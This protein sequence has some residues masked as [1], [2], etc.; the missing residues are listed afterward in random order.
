MAWPDWE[1][2]DLITADGLNERRQISV[3]KTSLESRTSTIAM[4]ADSELV[5]P[6]RA[7]FTYAIDAVINYTAISDG[8]DLRYG[9]SIPGGGSTIWWN[10]HSLDVAVTSQSGSLNTAFNSTP[11]GGGARIAGAVAAGITAMYLRGI[12]TAN[13]DGNLSFIW[14]QGVSSANAV[15]VRETS[16]IIVTPIR[17]I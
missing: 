2:G 1:A 13:V 12:L 16:F 3:Y 7:G 6:V 4:A 10:N 17:K 15:T 5:V 14:A 9:W 8:V 11:T